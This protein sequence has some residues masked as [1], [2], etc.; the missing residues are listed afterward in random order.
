VDVLFGNDVESLSF[1]GVIVLFLLVVWTLLSAFLV[2]DIISGR[3]NYRE[4]ICVH[5]LDH[6]KRNDFQESLLES[7][8]AK[9]LK[10]IEDSKG[11]TLRES[12][13]RDNYHCILEYVGSNLTTP[14]DAGWEAW[15]WGENDVQ[16]E[17]IQKLFESVPKDDSG[18]SANLVDIAYKEY[19]SC[20]VCCWNKKI[21][22][23]L[24]SHFRTKVVGKL[25]GSILG[26][27]GTGGTLGLFAGLMLS[28]SE[29][30]LMGWQVSIFPMVGTVMGGYLRSVFFFMLRYRDMSIWRQAMIYCV[31][32]TIIA[33]VWF[34][35]SVL[36][37]GFWKNPPTIV[38]NILALIGLGV[39][40]RYLGN[41]KSRNSG[42]S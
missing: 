26:W 7:K 37:L 17:R 12:D 18:R 19:K 11:V 2:V 14:V 32:V 10:K 36:L 40:V 6:L 35:L 31:L 39:A 5:I 1:F 20:S 4:A 34:F 24:G 3:Q 27:A 41:D 38:V 15:M 42:G 9:K 25:L 13:I 28:F 16:K 21:K 22:G 8:D 33:V 30:H 23:V 29:G